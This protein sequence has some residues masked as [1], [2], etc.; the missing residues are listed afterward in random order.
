VIA[1]QLAV[2]HGPFE[3]P[4]RPLARLDT[5]RPLDELLAQLAT[6]L[7]ARLGGAS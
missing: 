6:E 3:P 2:H 5:T 7:D 1:A 4:G